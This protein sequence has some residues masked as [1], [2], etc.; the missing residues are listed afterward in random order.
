MES[1]I[2]SERAI[3][4]HFIVLRT[5][6]KDIGRTL[7]TN[8]PQLSTA[9]S[10]SNHCLSFS[11]LR[12]IH[13]LI[14]TNPQYFLNAL[15]S[16]IRI[17]FVDFPEK[18]LEKGKIIP[19]DAHRRLRQEGLFTEDLLDYVSIQFALGLFEK[20]DLLHLLNV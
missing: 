12:H 20:I 10:F 19:P 17:L 2:I 5:K 6:C 7:R 18:L 15:S 16:I 4:G 13:N 1:N 8:K 3:E 9:V 11:T 14:F